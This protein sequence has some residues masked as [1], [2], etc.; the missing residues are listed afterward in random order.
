MARKP[1]HQTGLFGDDPAP[2]GDPAALVIVESKGAPLGKAQRTFNRLTATIRKQ[3]EAL[4]IWDD[5]LPRLQQR[6][7]A[8]LAPAERDIRES[9]RRLAARLDAVLEAPGKG[10]RLGKRQR[11]TAIRHLLGLIENI[12][13]SG[14]DPELEMIYDRY[15][16]TSLAQRRQEEVSYAEEVLGE[17]LGDE[18]LQGHKARNLDE[19]F[20]HARAKAEELDAAQEAKKAQRKAKRRSGSTKAEQATARKEQARIEAGRSIREIFR[21]LA[22]ALHPD[23]EPDPAECER[24]TLLMQRVNQAYERNDLLALLAL[25][26]E[27]EQIDADHLAGLSEER[28]RH[29]NEVLSEQLKALEAEMEER[30]APLR[31]EFGLVPWS[32]ITTATVD[33]ALDERIDETLSLREQLETDLRALDDPHGRRVLFKNLADAEDN[34]EHDVFDAMLAMAEALDESTFAPEPAKGRRGKKRR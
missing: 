26:L 34:D 1:P 2:A 24:K 33:A 10:E 28:L 14:P 4:A 22:S 12:L 6:V 27:T 16:D 21:K 29:Y 8:E 15:S 32:V 11:A 18:A 20:A 13:E 17:F 3:R 31:F 30:L 19:L 9:Q 7:M 25:Q 5:Y 23:R